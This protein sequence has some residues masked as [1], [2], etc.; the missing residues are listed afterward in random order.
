MPDGADNAWVGQHQ[1]LYEHIGGLAAIEMVAG[2]MFACGLIPI[3]GSICSAVALISAVA[4]DD[5]VGVGAAAAGM[6]GGA[7]VGATLK[8]ATTAIAR[9]AAMAM[10]VEFRKDV[11]QVV[12]SQ[13]QRSR[14]M[15]DG[16]SNAIGSA[17]TAA[18]PRP[19]VK[20]GAGGGGGG[21]RPWMMF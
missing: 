17:I 11:K 9:E 7:A 8:L 3:A 12:S 10:K 5:W 14:L 13:Q 4:Q 15:R 18:I 6:V 1:K 20:S 19:D 2:A 16:V 21:V